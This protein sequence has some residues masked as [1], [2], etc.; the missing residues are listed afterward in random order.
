MNEPQK[1]SP[2][3]QVGSV[4]RV[5]VE[6]AQAALRGE[7]VTAGDRRVARRLDECKRCPQ[8]TLAGSCALCGCVVAFKTK[9]AAASCPMGKW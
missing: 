1:L 9:V 4:F 5:A 7:A 6:S 8:L 3:Q 2:S